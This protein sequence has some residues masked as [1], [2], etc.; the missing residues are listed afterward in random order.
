[1][2]AVIV[3][4]PDHWHQQISIDA[5]NAGKHVYCEKPMVHS[6]DEGPAVIAAQKKTGKVFQVGSQGVSSWV[7]RK[8]K[9]Y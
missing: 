2:D 1:M 6:V 9:N 5:M 8:P 4:T 3:A 7:M